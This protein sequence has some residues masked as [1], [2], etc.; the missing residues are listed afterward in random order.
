M[1]IYLQFALWEVQ[2]HYT[3]LGQGDWALL[4]LEGN[5]KV[6]QLMI[7]LTLGEITLEETLLS[8]HLQ[9]FLFDFPSK[10]CQS[11]GIHGHMFASAG[12]IDKL[13]ENAYQNFSL[14]KFVESFRTSVGVGVIIPTNLFR[15]EVRNPFLLSLP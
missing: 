13:T 5:C 7:M 6:I 9:T 4:I 8:P 14:Q 2:W 11:K 1:V 10:W 12:N 3:G 15:L